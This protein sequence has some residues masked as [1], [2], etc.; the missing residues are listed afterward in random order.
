MAEEPTAERPADAVGLGGEGAGADAGGGSGGGSGGGG[1][2]GGAGGGGRGRAAHARSR[3]AHARSRPGAHRRGRGLGGVVRAHPLASALAGLAVVVL[4][5]LAWALAWYEGEVNPGAQGPAVVVTVH[6]G[7]SAGGVADLLEREHVVGSALALRIYF[8]LHG[9]PVIGSGGYLLHQHTPFA[10]V[11][12]AFVRGPDVFTVDVVPGFT[13]EE[14]AARVGDVPGHSADAF[15]SLARSGTIR[16]PYAPAGVDNPDGL[17]GTGP[18]QVLP[19]ETDATLLQ[20]MIDRFDR[21]AQAVG[22]VPG[23]AALG[24]TP[25]QVVTVASIVEKEGVYSQN[26]AKVARVVYN[27]L[28]K[29][30]P[31]QMDS[32]VL[33]S[34][35]RD[36]GTVT[37]ADLALNTPYN[38]YLHTG[39]TPSP[40]CFPSQD[41]LEAALHPSAGDWLY[42]VVVQRDGTEAFADTYAEQ[43][44]NEQLAKSRGVG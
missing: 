41:A 5:L 9:T 28:A 4:G 44:A 32:T 12:A 11:R 14:V 1:A 21:T 33:Y 36:G 37:S 23:S 27:R 24:M 20:Q 29:G 26:L 31:L 15:L 25:Y 2:G 43:L 19:G 6:S 30:M 3:A 40:I 35:H 7:T 8:L 38:T 18:Y 17:L 16:S 39:L 42:F 34:E 10:A 13:V 22:L